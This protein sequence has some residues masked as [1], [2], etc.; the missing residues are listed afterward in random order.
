VAGAKKAAVLVPDDRVEGRI[1][2]A[3]CHFY[4]S[5]ARLYLVVKKVGPGYVYPWLVVESRVCRMLQIF[6]IAKSYVRD[7]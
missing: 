2:E 1:Y 3:T 5:S 6:N 7:Q 4:S